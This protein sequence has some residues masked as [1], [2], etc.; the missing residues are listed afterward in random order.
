[1]DAAAPARLAL[2]MTSYA[3]C[4]L[5]YSRE[6]DARAS[7]LGELLA[8][9]RGLPWTILE[10]LI[11]GARAVVACAASK[12]RSEAYTI[13]LGERIVA[14]DGATA[15]L[16]EEGLVPSIVVTDLDGPWDALLEAQRR[17]AVLVVHVHGDNVDEVL[18]FTARSGKVVF[19]SQEP[20][21]ARCLPLSGFTDGERA[22]EVALRFGARSVRVVGADF[23]E[24][25]V[26]G[27]SKPWLRG[28]TRAWPEKRVKLW[29]ARMFFEELGFYGA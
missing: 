20:L 13:G 11:R 29:I 8:C 15:L 25:I 2:R 3:R 16:L 12:L 18:E 27:F 1:M 21:G 17:G 14:A 19:S 9:T 28:D 22:L 24:M 23:E 6:G 5:G 4:A 26:G 7:L 10:D